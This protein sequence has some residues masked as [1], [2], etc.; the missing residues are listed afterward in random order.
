MSDFSKFPHE[1][2]PWFE[3]ST[4]GFDYPVSQGVRHYK[5]K[6]LVDQ[7]C[8]DALGYDDYWQFVERGRERDDPSPQRVTDE[9]S[10]FPFGIPPSGGG[11]G[12]GGYG[13][14]GM[15]G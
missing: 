5:T 12:G 4:C 14:G 9:G 6:K 3:C 7:K 11:Y 13:G 1:G 15:G 2:E 10:V 8:A